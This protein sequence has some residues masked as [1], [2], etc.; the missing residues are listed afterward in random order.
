[1]YLV[2]QY[3]IL[4]FLCIK[5]T[6]LLYPQCVP[7]VSRHHRLAIQIL[8]S[9]IHVSMHYSVSVPVCDLYPCAYG[10]VQ[11]SRLEALAHMEASS[12]SSLEACRISMLNDEAMKFSDAVLKFPY[13][14]SLL[15]QPECLL[16][17]Q[18]IRKHSRIIFWRAHNE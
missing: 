11:F 2:V 6:S 10:S 8:N 3:P 9:I 17:L 7:A 4:H 12:F 13:C 15:I 5:S 18:K 14:N 16:K 1:M